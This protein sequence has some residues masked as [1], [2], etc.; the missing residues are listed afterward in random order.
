MSILEDLSN[1]LKVLESD[2]FTRMEKELNI[3]K[4]A[5]NLKNINNTQN[6]LSEKRKNQE[7]LISTEQEE[8]DNKQYLPL[9][10]IKD[11]NINEI[12][13]EEDKTKEEIKKETQ[14]EENKCDIIKNET[15]KNDMIDNKEIIKKEENN[16]NNN[17]INDNLNK[18]NEEKIKNKIFEIKQDENKKENKIEEKIITLDD[19]PLKRGRKRKIKKEE[20]DS[21][22]EPNSA[23]STSNTPISNQNE[24]IELDENEQ[25]MNNN[26]KE[27]ENQDINKKEENKE[28]KEQNNKQEELKEFKYY[29]SNQILN[30]KKIKWDIKLEKA[31]GWFSIGIGERKK[32][33][34]NLLNND[35][36]FEIL[37]D[38][39]ESIKYKKNFLLTNDH[40]TI[41]WKDGNMTYKHIKGSLPIKEGDIL[42]FIYSP[43]YEQLKISKKNFSFTISNVIYDKNEIIVPVAIFSQ[44]YDSVK[45][46]NF[47]ILAD[48][49]K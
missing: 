14:L 1:R 23:K 36:D 5:L 29:Y 26:K 12:K 2:R 45:F 11:D 40:C 6:F 34:Q 25:E 15:N 38:K 17:N 10:E 49:S 21:S 22:F 28:I 30:D 39:K 24:I 16:V 27:K 7:I 37:F 19:K 46:F 44:K 35:K 32:Q 41:L 13:T 8:I 18:T 48:Y 33:E 4:D 3:I 47:Q 9:N 31:K 42:S 20:D 43:K